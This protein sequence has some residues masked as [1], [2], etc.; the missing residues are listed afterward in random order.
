MPPCFLPRITNSR[1][2]SGSEAGGEPLGSPLQRSVSF[3]LLPTLGQ[4]PPAYPA[5]YHVRDFL[6]TPRL[7]ATPPSA[8]LLPSVP[9]QAADLFQLCKGYRA[10]ANP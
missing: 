3:C 8:L 10:R 5:V 7:Y 2:G 6:S 4:A 9:L 1:A